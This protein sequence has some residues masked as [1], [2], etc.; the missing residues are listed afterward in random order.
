MYILPIQQ[1]YG[2]QHMKTENCQRV[3]ISMQQQNEKQATGFKVIVVI[4]LATFKTMSINIKY[5]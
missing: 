1:Y 5:T 3:P 2:V 4:R